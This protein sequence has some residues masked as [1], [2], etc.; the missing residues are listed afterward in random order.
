M[1][2]AIN[3]TAEGSTSRCW[4]WDQWWCHDHEYC[5]LIDIRT[6]NNKKQNS[7]M[8]KATCYCEK[9]FISVELWNLHIVLCGL[10]NDKSA[11]VE[12][13]IHP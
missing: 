8:I 7:D 2:F 12:L 1:C 10:I 11:L 3:T 6:G 4:L 9:Q 5:H 13:Y